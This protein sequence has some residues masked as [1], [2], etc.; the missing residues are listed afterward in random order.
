MK[1]LLHSYWYMAVAVGVALVVWV[2]CTPEKGGSLGAIPKAAFTVA[3]GGNSDTVILTNT[4]PGVISYFSVNGGPLISAQADTVAFTFQGT[5]TVKQTVF[6]SGGSDTT[7][8]TVTINQNNPTACAMGVQGFLTGCS[9]KTWMLNPTA[10]AEGIGPS[11]GSD[12]WWGNGASEPTGDRVCDFNDTWTFNFNAAASMVYDNQGDYY[13]EG[14]L[15]NENNDCDV[16]ADL[17]P[18]DQPWASGTFSYQLIANAG[19]VP[20][21]GQ[22][23]LIGLGAHIGLARVQ[24]GADGTG[25]LPVASTTYDIIDTAH[26]ASGNAIL[27]ISING[28]GGDWWTWVLKSSN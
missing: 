1:R 8:Q 14:Y 4:T 16:N 10:N 3:G 7:S 23:K 6:G 12:A 25:D 19:S 17:A 27:T 20:G 22:L 13:T 21:L 24:N 26:D 5:Y 15:G 11:F 28:S 18:A 9:G 2:G